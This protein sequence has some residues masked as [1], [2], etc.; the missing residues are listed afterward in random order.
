MCFLKMHTKPRT[1]SCSHMGINFYL[2]GLKCRKEESSEFELVK[3]FPSN[4]DEMME[5]ERVGKKT[6]LHQSW[7]S[8]KYQSTCWIFG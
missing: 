3:V 8:K 6:T 2:K 5:E 4:T 1:P 7:M